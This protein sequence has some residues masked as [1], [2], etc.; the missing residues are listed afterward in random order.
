MTREGIASLA[1]A[2]AAVGVVLTSAVLS[3]GGSLIEVMRAPDK[4]HP[5]VPVYESGNGY[6]LTGTNHAKAVAWA[7]RERAKR[8]DFRDGAPVLKRTPKRLAALV[9]D[10][11]ATLA[12][13]GA[14]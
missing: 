11:F 1:A 7:G 4:P 8:Y 14:A 6:S 12:E 13:R 5:P 9:R 2:L 10:A 3:D